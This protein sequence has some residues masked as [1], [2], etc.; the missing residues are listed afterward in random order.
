MKKVNYFLLCENLL[1]D[2]KGRI[3]LVNIF[4]TINAE[5][6]PVAPLRFSIALSI[7]LDEEDVVDG[8]VKLGFEVLNAKNKAIAK[9]EGRADVPNTAGNVVTVVELGGRILLDSYKEYTV[10]LK[11]NEHFTDE[12]KFNIVKGS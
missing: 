1:K 7:K 11:V 5:N 2:E 8:Q 12:F 6:L 10:K 9:A 4:D 3:T